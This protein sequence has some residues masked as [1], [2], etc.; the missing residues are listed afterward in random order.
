M[1]K[2][3]RQPTDVTNTPPTTGPKAMDTPTTA[4]QMPTAWARSRGMVKVFVMI[5]MATG[6]SIDPADGLNHP[7]DNE[8]AQ[9]G[10]EAAEQRS[11]A[12]VQSPMTK[13]LRRPRRSAVE[14]EIIRRLARTSV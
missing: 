12:K 13:V 11:R 10:G 9:V 4:P 6:L 14:P 3:D 2:I 8:R 5:D 7:E 1:K